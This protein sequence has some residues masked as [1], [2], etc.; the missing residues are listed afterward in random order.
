MHMCI[1]FC[2]FY[3]ICNG[4]GLSFGVIGLS[5]RIRDLGIHI[6]HYNSL[7][8]KLSKKLCLHFAVIAKHKTP[9]FG[10]DGSSTCYQ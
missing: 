9:F 2:L 3:Y 5:A 6:F 4:T 10:N 8:A 7:Q 1:H